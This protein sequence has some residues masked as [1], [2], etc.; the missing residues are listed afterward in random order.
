MKISVIGAGNV[1]ATLAQRIVDMDLA[2]E[3][4]LLDIIE[5]TPQGKA[6]DMWEST[7]ITGSDCR[8]VGTNDYKDTAKSDIV[9]ITA[10]LPRKP[11][12]SREDLLEKNVAIVKEVAENVKKT[13]PNSIVVV[14]SNP[15]DA[16]VYTAQKVTG[17]EPHRVFGMAGILDTARYRSF[18]ALELD[19]STRDIQALVLGG[20][21][22]E[23]VPLPR[24]TMV[25]GIP[26]TELLPKDRIDAILERTRK[27]GGEIVALLKTGSAYYATSAA[28]IEIVESIVKDKKRLLPCSAYLQ[29]EYGYEGIYFGVPI[30]IGRSGVEKIYELTLNAEEKEALKKSADAVKRT[31][32]E[33]KL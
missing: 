17:F 19:V 30:K 3:C 11:G 1:G 8:I 16:M 31:I 4:A 29:G 33:I 28:V 12:M 26:L 5:G 24:Y 2:R 25:G 13:S 7:P 9:V 23:M 6:L 14:V 22:D 10:G 20:H 21:G 32:G 18:V 27:G 15:L